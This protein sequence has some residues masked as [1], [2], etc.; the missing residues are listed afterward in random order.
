MTAPQSEAILARQGAW[1]QSTLETLL[2]GC[3]WQYFLTYVLGIEGAKK[4]ASISGSGYHAAIEAYEKARAVGET[5]T[6][7][8]MLTVASDY[9]AAHIDDPKAVEE[10]RQA[11]RH[12]YQTPTADGTSH[13]EWLAQYTP[14]AIEPYFRQ[15]LVADELPIAGWI[16]GVYQHQETGQVILVDHKTANN[17]SRWGYD[18]DEHRA[19]ATMYATALILSGDYPV[20]DLVPMH[21]L[22]S[23]KTRGRSKSFEGARRVTVHPILEDVR[24]LGDRIRKAG[25]IVR[26]ESYVRR[27]EWILCSQQWCP[28][29]E[30]CMITKDLAGTPAQVQA[31]HANQIAGILQNNNTQSPTTTTGGN[32]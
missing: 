4:P 3:S 6:L 28:H 8:A 9:V 12:W 13:R 21:Y 27:P 23:R 24:V 10:S 15:E 16:D 5:F 29:Y 22:V 30:G 25:Q 20:S 2:D 7:D 19:Q 11:V 17:L 18:G 1:H 32:Q 14:I 26:T 31:R